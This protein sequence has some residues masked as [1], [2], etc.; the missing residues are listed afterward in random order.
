MRKTREIKASNFSETADDAGG[1][2]KF[3][4]VTGGF[5]SH[6]GS[7]AFRGRVEV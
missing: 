6:E 1:C 7:L 3:S 4:E 2:R 5:G